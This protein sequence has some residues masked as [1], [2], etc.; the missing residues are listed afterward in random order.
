[1]QAQLLREPYQGLEN[2]QRAY[3]L[4]RKPLAGHRADVASP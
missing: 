1:M 4:A 3:L 2:D